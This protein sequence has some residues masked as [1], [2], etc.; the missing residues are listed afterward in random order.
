MMIV[1]RPKFSPTVWNVVLR[2]MP[3]TTPGSAIGR[4]RTKLIESRPKNAKRCTAMAASVPSTRAMATA[5]SAASNEFMN[6]SGMAELA[7]ASPN[8]RRVNPVGGQAMKEL[9]L[10]AW[11]PTMTSGR[12]RKARISHVAARRATRTQPASATRCLHHSESNAPSRRATR[13]YTIITM[14]GSIEYA[15]ATGKLPSAELS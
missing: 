6:A 9:S 12:Y 3:V 4:T 2:A 5:P 11:M 10:K 15:A 14:I 13:R 1:I 8:Q 7:R